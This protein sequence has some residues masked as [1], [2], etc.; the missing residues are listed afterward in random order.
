MGVKLARSISTDDAASLDEGKKCNKAGNKRRL[1]N[2]SSPC[3]IVVMRIRNTDLRRPQQQKE[4]E[5]REVFRTS[6]SKSAHTS[7]QVATKTPSTSA[8]VDIT[9]LIPDPPDTPQSF[10]GSIFASPSSF[11]GVSPDFYGLIAKLPSV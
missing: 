10:G 8:K 1:I 3:T 5:K 2:G 6:P 7:R 11:D 9:A 4:D